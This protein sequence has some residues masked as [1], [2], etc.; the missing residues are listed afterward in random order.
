MHAIDYRR[1][2]RCQGFLCK[3]W[4]AEHSIELMRCVNCGAQYDIIA[5]RHVPRCHCGKA[6]IEG[7]KVCAACLYDKGTR[8]ARKAKIFYFNA[9]RH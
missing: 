2:M 1:C 7:K 3:T 5:P 9:A 6:V 8:K 4:D